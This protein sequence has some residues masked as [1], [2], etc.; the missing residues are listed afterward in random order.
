MLLLEAS[1][2]CSPGSEPQLGFSRSLTP[3]R[4]AAK[5]AASQDLLAP[6]TSTST[7]T[8]LLLWESTFIFS[9]CLFVFSQK[10]SSAHQLV[11][12]A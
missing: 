11:L 2:E 8:H 7:S 4:P 12:P 1:E 3:A 9:I 6:P 5:R 10:R